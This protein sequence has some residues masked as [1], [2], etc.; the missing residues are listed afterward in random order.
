MKKEEYRSIVGQL[1]IKC[2][3][4]Q[5][6]ALVCPHLTPKE[7]VK[8]FM[9][10]SGYVACPSIFIK[11][12][13]E[14]ISYNKEWVEEIKD[15][16][17]KIIGRKNHPAYLG[18][19]Y[20]GRTRASYEDLTPHGHISLSYK[21][22]DKAVYLSGSYAGKTE[23]KSSH[24]DLFLHYKREKE[25]I[26]FA[27]ANWGDELVVDNWVSVV[28]FFIQDPTDLVNDT[29]HTDSPR[30]KAVLGVALSRD[31]SSII[32]DR[33]KPTSELFDEAILHMTLDNVAWH[34]MKGG[35]GGYTEFN[36]AHCGSGLSLSSC[37][38][39]GHSF[40]DNQIRGGWNTP[41]SKKMVA[42]LQEAGHEFKINPEI[43]WNK[44]FQKW[45]QAI[46]AYKF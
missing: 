15:K 34:E 33:S 14:I 38:G 8:A 13:F 2:P 40:R 29:Y 35:R 3:T 19:A 4:P 20:A 17:G 23:N 43:A 11:N 27:N 26:K 7:A 22:A 46:K 18:W 41:L 36:C 30:T 39:C 9:T 32:N 21:S 5:D 16:D 37:M 6:M 25:A 1:P 44:E 12:G 42:F 45:E 24:G 31:L 10:G 28:E